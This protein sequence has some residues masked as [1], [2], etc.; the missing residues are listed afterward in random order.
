MSLGLPTYAVLKSLLL[1]IALWILSEIAI[2]P[3]A[4]NGS[5][6]DAIFT[7]SPKT[8]LF[9]IVTSPSCIPI[10]RSRLSMDLV[11]SCMSIAHSTAEVTLL[12]ITNKP[13]P[14]SFIK[15]LIIG[16]LIYHFFIR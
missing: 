2:P 6:R 11:F 7:S 10:L 3:T 15:G 5:I 8:S 16:L 12:K 9:L 13:S 1:E 14:I 4:E